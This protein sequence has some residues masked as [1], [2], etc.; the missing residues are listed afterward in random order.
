[1]HDLPWQGDNLLLSHQLQP[2]AS[3]DEVF[4]WLAKGVKP[5]MTALPSKGCANTQLTASLAKQLGVAKPPVSIFNGEL[6]RKKP[7][8]IGQLKK[9]SGGLSLERIEP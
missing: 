5:R 4:G 1:M 3:K 9:L 2:K 8:R 6:G 7:V